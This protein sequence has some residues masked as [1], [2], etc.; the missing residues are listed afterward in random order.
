MSPG[1]RGE[2]PLA[3]LRQSVGRLPLLLRHMEPT[4]FLGG[5][6][7]LTPGFVERHG[8][9]GLIWDVDGT[10]TAYHQTR[11]LAEVEKPF[12]A[13]R[14]LPGLR[15]AILSNAP[16]WRFRQLAEMFPTIP[17]LRGYLH[18]GEVLGRTLL[19]PQDSWSAEALASRLATGATVI[20]KPHAGLVQL[21]IAELGCPAAGVV[22]V[23]DQHLT[24]VAGASLAGVRSVKLPNAAP[25]TFPWSIRGTQ[26]LE[27]LLYR[28]RPR[29]TPSSRT[30]Q[31]GP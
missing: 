8:I 12:A 24:D 5:V 26:R 20:R 13:L 4:W 21:A 14:A 7:D 11:V 10:L 6:A 2:S 3:T 27:T 22:M 17:V 30:P 29:R 9:Q 25:S 19:G 16:E 18:G 28:L 31:A 23:G 15:H 1:A